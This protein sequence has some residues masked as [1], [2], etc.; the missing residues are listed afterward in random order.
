MKYIRLK[1]IDLFRGLCMSW[2]VIA[3]LV[4]WWTG[5]DDYWIFTLLTKIFEPIGASG[6][7]FISGVSIT[8]SYRSRL[9]RIKNQEDY[10][11]RILRHFYFFRAILIFIVAIIYNSTVALRTNDLSMIWTWFVLLTISI[12]LFLGWPLLKTRKI[13][14]IFIAIMIIIIQLFIRLWLFPFEGNSNVYGVIFHI[15][16]N[17]KTQ[18]P[19]LV[20]FP[21]F[22]IGTVL[23]DFYFDTF[24]LDKKH[25]NGKKFIKKILFPCCLIGGS[26]IVFGILFEFPRFLLRQTFSWIIYSI[27]IEITLI[28]ILLYL[29]KFN[30]LQS[31]KSYKWLFYF[32]FYSLTIYLGHNL[33]YFLFLDKLNIITLW[34]PII[35]AYISLALI[36][37]A[38]YKLW[39]EKAA[40]KVYIAKM[41]L[42]L[43]QKIE[44]RFNKHVN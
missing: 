16:Y 10:N 36:L 27:G 34:I 31:K 39:K 11:Y 28:S 13:F 41:S 43:A 29:E 8:L 24:Y 40:I 12:S 33:L 2:M 26:L 3:H 25:N 42:Y 19:I 5:P 22:L 7:L 44:D 23:G 14:R 32:S 4:D 37:R 15:L 18:D 20:F 9:A 21:Y 38:V 6:F 1:S 17:G 35:I 30:Y